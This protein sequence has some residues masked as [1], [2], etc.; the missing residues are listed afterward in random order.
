MLNERFKH[1][2]W[3][4]GQKITVKQFLDEVLEHDSDYIIKVQ[5]K[6][7]EGGILFAGS[8]AYYLTDRRYSYKLNMQEAE[9][10]SAHNEYFRERLEGLRN[11]G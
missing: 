1:H 8:Y 3:F 10:L 11:A 4:K 7:D 2:A 6:S 9:Y 5:Y